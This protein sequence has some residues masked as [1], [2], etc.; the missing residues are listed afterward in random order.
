MLELELDSDDFEE[1]L[2]LSELFDEA[3]LGL[4]ADEVDDLLEGDDELL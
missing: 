3:E 4:E 1:L 2:E